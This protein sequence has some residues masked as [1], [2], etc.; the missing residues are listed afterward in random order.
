MPT[1]ERNPMA[2]REVCSSRSQKPNVLPTRR[3]GSP[4]ENPSNN[5]VRVLGRR[6]SLIRCL[7][8]LTRPLCTGA[9]RNTTRTKFIHRNGRK[10][11]E[12][13]RKHICRRSTLMNAD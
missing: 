11:R 12:E 9:S 3:K 7:C 4:E 1:Q 13:K 2:V 5:I 8:A 6:Y 10:G